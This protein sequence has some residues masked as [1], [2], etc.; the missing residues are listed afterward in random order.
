MGHS[1]HTVAVFAPVL[2]L[3]VT[4]EKTSSGEDEVHI[5]PGGQ[6]F[7]IARML[8]HLEERPLL[9]GPLGG[10]AGKVFV[11]LLSQFKMD[12]S[13]TTIS[14]RS[15][16]VISDR[17]SGERKVVADSPPISLERHE[18]DDMYG[19]YL[20]RAIASGICVIT[21]QTDEIVPLKFF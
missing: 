18:V 2:Y 15:P 21:G 10:E 11:G 20:D 13:P 12:M 19:R 6:G 17:R 1:E 16:V 8:K 3:T 14:T 9:C 7:W 4:I 5:H